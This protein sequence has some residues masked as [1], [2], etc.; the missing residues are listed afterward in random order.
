MAY[1]RPRALSRVLNSLN[2]ARLEEVSDLR[3]I[4]SIDGGGAE[5]VCEVGRR[6]EW[7]YGPKELICHEHNLGLRKHILSCG[8]L[9]IKHGSVM[10]LEDDCYV[11]PNFYQ[12]AVEALKNYASEDQIAGVSLYTHQFNEN[13]FLPFRALHDGYDAYFMQVPSS[14]GQV[15]TSGQ[16]KKFKEWYSRK[17]L[18]APE[19][20]LPSNVKKWPETSWK[21]YFYKY[22]LDHDLY[23]VYPAVSHLTNFSDTG[24]THYELLSRLHQVPLEQRDPA[25]PFRFATFSVSL[26]KYDGFFELEAASYIQ[27][28]INIDPDTLI[29]LYG[30]KPIEKY[31]HKFLLSSKE[32]KTCH[33][34]YGGDMFPF[35]LN[36]LCKNA[37]DFFHYG[38]KDQFG[39]LKTNNIR[40]MASASQA[41]GFNQGRNSILS[42]RSYKLGSYISNP[43]Q[44]F[45]FLGRKIKTLI[46][47]K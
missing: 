30:S 14:L 12:F 26:N 17:T 21:K 31:E 6:F 45:K 38:E 16:W 46:S 15:W 41:V 2:K 43:L 44:S 47:P 36:I 34:A 37:G 3:L 42:T 9:S 28:G 23:F 4:I 10:I 19:D 5:E 8:D 33:E 25:I 40:T 20:K 24:G 11:S 27:Q 29:D 22:M 13:V 1:N 39:S 35:H 7:D 32:C 18:I